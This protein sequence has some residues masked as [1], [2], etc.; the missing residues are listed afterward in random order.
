MP[1]KLLALLCVGG[2]AFMAYQHLTKRQEERNHLKTHGEKTRALITD[3][4]IDERD[5]RP[6]LLRNKTTHKN[7]QHHYLTIEFTMRNGDIVI[8]KMWVQPQTHQQ[9]A[10]DDHIYVMFDPNDPQLVMPQSELD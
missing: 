1:L 2:A 8:G 4:F 6:S 9:Y 7:T 5:Y 3:K 10:I